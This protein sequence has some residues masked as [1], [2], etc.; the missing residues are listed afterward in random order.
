MESKIGGG[1]FS[2]DQADATFYVEESIAII[3]ETCQD[4]KET[5][6]ILEWKSGFDLT[7]FND[8]S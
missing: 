2:R 7:Y 6:R 4:R 8:Q 3:R 5:K 1:R